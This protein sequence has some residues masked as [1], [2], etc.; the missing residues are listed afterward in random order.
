MLLSNCFTQEAYS[1][2]ILQNMYRLCDK[3][4]ENC[5]ASTPKDLSQSNQINIIT[6]TIFANILPVL[7][8]RPIYDAVTKHKCL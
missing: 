1:S 5:K 4:F 7:F 3:G 6:T 8:I 2:N